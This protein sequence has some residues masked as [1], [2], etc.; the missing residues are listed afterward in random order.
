MRNP[1]PAIRNNVSGFV[2]SMRRAIALQ[3]TSTAVVRAVDKI[4]ERKAWTIDQMAAIISALETEGDSNV[5]VVRDALAQDAWVN[6]AVGKLAENV[7]RAEWEI[8]R[9]GEL[10]EDGPVVELFRN[11]N[12]YMS[13]YQLWEATTIYEQA[14]GEVFWIFEEDY[15]V[16]TL[17]QELYVIDPRYFTH[18]LSP[19]KRRIT[20]WVYENEE[21]KIPFL[22]DELIHFKLFNPWSP[23]RGINPLVAMSSELSQ[24]LLINRNSNA[25]L[26]NYSV[27]AGVIELPETETVQEEEATRIKKAW[28]KDHSGRK[29]H[30]IGILSA[31]A[32]YH[33]IA[34]TDAE[35]QHIGLSK[36][37]RDKILSKYGVPPRVAGLAEDS[38]SLSGQD[39]N[40]Q[41]KMFWQ[42]KLIPILR[43]YEDK[44]ATDFFGRLTAEGVSEA[45]GLSGRFNLHNIAELQEDQAKRS[46]ID[47]KEVLAGIQ[48]INQVREARGWDPVP[49]GDV[50]W[51]PIALVPATM[52]T[53]EPEPRDERMVKDVVFKPK[54]FE[55]TDLYK[56][57]HWKQLIAEWEAV[58]AEYIRAL[59][60]WI[61]AIR[62]MVLVEAFGKS[63]KVDEIGP[64]LADFYANIRDIKD[65]LLTEQY[66]L[67]QQAELERLSTP[68]FVA[69]MDATGAQLKELFDDMGIDVSPNWSI[70]DTRAIEL[71][72]TRVTQGSLGEITS[73]MRKELRGNLSHIISDGLSEKEAAEAIRK[74]F[75]IFGNRSAT[76]ART[77]I[78]GVINDSRDAAFDEIGATETEWLSSRDLNVRTPPDSAFNH[79][80]DGT[81]RKRGE[82]FPTGGALIY[83][84][85]IDGHAGDIIN[86]RCLVLPVIE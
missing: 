37:N 49:W 3:Q 46:E 73:T 74:Q 84:S 18:K 41:R 36:M 28:A 4:I 79:M 63:L 31:G 71:L 62:S 59:Q 40:E 54:A 11:V 16:N 24:D 82:P 9:D 42:L 85:H 10:V 57:M 34:M 27:P 19:D 81:R 22:P 86:C 21:V 35:A 23:W 69:G 66:F 50:W 43:A 78:G 38:S 48:L 5:Y 51:K 33:A 8:I 65:D 56:E 83:P 30:T 6:I 15:A 64:G 67:D 32:K 60:K 17:P 76:I 12:P 20:L 75:S 45:R 26:E 39:S 52:D 55:W 25:L 68:F 72:N 61:F 7:A 2:K 1:L 58:E 47:Q 70:H 29:S 80:L 77:E 44:A 14:R 53:E 13:R